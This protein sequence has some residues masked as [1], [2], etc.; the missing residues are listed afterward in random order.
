[1]IKIPEIERLIQ[2]FVSNTPNIRG[3]IL[4]SSEGL[5]L[6]SAFSNVF[7]ED[8][9]A[10]ITVSLLSLGKKF[11]RDLTTGAIERIII[12]GKEGYCVLIGC[13]EDLIL[14][15]LASKDMVKGWL[16]VEIKTLIKTMKLIMRTSSLHNNQISTTS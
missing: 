15:V 5:P 16:F 13:E 7:D 8:K 11:E 6:T 2:S 4:V 3:A 14:L 12:E 10:A 1:M 9:A